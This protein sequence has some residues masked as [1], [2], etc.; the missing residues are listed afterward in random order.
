MTSDEK[1]QLEEMRA[2]AMARQGDIEEGE[3]ELYEAQSPK[4]RFTAKG[5]NALVDATNRLLPMF[6]VDDAYERLS[7]TM[8]ELPTDF[9][10][11]LSMF[12]AAMDDAVQEGIL[13]EDAAIDLTVITDDS[14][15][16]ALAGRLNMAAKSPAFRRFLA[17]A[18]KEEKAPKA[19]ADAEADAEAVTGEPVMS[20]EDLFM[21]RM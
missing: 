9:V 14:G 12:K 3:D 19:E 4:G 21:S 16:Q 6:G 15:L 13:P 1:M 20:D 17:R 2:T 8:T 7:G 11:L 5:A 18:T 10:R